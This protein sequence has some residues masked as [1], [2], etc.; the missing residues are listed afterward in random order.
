[1]SKRTWISL[2]CLVL[3]LGN[4]LGMLPVNRAHAQ[5]AEELELVDLINA[6][7]ARSQD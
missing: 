2:V 1:M 4:I 7:R 5:S 3:I 6:L